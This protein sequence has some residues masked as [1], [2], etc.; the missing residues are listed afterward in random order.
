MGKTAGDCQSWLGG[1]SDGRVN[2]S[3]TGMRWL[4]E[5]ASAGMGSKYLAAQMAVLAVG[6]HHDFRCDMTS[7]LGRGAW[8]D[9]IYSDGAKKYYEE[10]IRR[11]LPP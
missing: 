10:S 8:R 11:F 3:S 2:H 6:C 5:S 1:E 4:L 9:R 7:P